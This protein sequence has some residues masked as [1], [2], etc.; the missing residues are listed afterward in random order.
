MLSILELDEY[1][2]PPSPVGSIAAQLPKDL[3]NVLKL[4]FH[5]SPTHPQTY[6]IFSFYPSLTKISLLLI[7]SSSF[8]FSLLHVSSCRCFLFPFQYSYKLSWIS[9]FLPF[10]VLLH[11]T[12][13]SYTFQ[14][15]HLQYFSF[16]ERAVSPTTE[17]YHSCSVTINSG[18]AL[19][20]GQQQQQCSTRA[21]S[22]TTAV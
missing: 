20:Q 17:V 22:P 5:P 3:L 8:S 9:L 15:N 2:R 12:S 10:F 21:V 4:I 6:F 13:S 1:S 19:V 11:S 16:W 14:I 7:L 18:V